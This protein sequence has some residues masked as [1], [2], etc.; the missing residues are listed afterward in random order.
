M[1]PLSPTDN[2]AA[3]W[4][5]YIKIPS[6]G[7]YTFRTVADNG[8][9]LLVNGNTLID[10][11]TNSSQRTLDSIS[12]NYTQGQLVTVTMD[13]YSSTGTSTAQLQWSY[14]GF[15]VTPVT[16]QLVP[17]SAFSQLSGTIGLRLNESDSSLTRS[18]KAGDTLQFSN[19]TS[20]R[21]ANDVTLSTTATVVNASLPATA[22]T[23]TVL[24]GETLSLPSLPAAQV[25]V[26][27]NDLPGFRI[28][29]D[30]AGLQTVLASDTITVNEADS[31]GA[32]VTRYLALTTQPTSTV[33]VYLE[34]SASNHGLL[35]APTSAQALAR[36][37]LTFTPSNW[38]IPQA[39]ATF[40]QQDNA[41]SGNANFAIFASSTS[42]DSLYNN[43]KPASNGKLFNVSKTDMDTPGIVSSAVTVVTG[44]GSNSNGSFTLKLNSKP[45][46]NVNVTLHPSDGQFTVNNASLNNDQTLVFTPDNWAIPQ[47]VQV[48]AVANTIV[49]DTTNSPL[50]IKSTSADPNYTNLTT[51]DV[52]IAITHNTLPTVRLELVGP[53]A[54]EDGQPATWRLVSNAPVPTSW[55]STGLVVGYNVT[56]SLS[57]ANVIGNGTESVPITSMV[58]G[59][60]SSGS[61]RI[62]PGQTTSNA[63]IM[64]ID[65]FAVDGVDKQFQLN[66][67]AGSGYTLDPFA[68]TATVS[69]K[70]NDVAGLMI[71]LAGERT[72]T[73]EGAGASQFQVCLLSQPSDTVTIQL[74]DISSVATGQSGTPLGQ[75]IVDN[76]TLTFTKDNWNVLQVVNV[77]ANDDNIIEDGTGLRAYTGIHT[78]QLQ[79][80][81][82]SNDGDYSSAGKP[83]AHFTKTSQAIDIVDR[84][85]DPRTYLGIDQALSAMMDGLNAMNLPIAGNLNGKTGPAINEFL[86][87]L[88]DS[89][90]TTPQL[91]SKKL[92][93]L[94]MDASGVNTTSPITMTMDSLGVSIDYTVSDAYNLYSIPLANDFGVPALGLQVSGSFDGSFDYSARLK[95]GVDKTRGFY[96]DTANSRLDAHYK[97]NLS[98]DFSLKG[99]LGFLQIDAVNQPSPHKSLGIIGEPIAGLTGERTGIDAT[100]RLKL[101]SPLAN[102]AES[103]YNDVTLLP[104]Q[105]LLSTDFSNL[106]RLHFTGQADGVLSVGMKAS[107]QDFSA[108]PLVSF[109]LST[110]M[111]LFYSTNPESPLPTLGTP[112]IP[113]PTNVFIDNLLLGMDNLIASLV[114]PLIT[115]IDGVLQPIYPFIQSLYDDTR[116][117]SRLGIGPKF[118]ANSDGSV[119]VIELAQYTANQQA[120]SNPNDPATQ[121]RLAAINRTVAFCDNLKAVI[122]LNEQLKSLSKDEN[123]LIE[124][125]NFVLSNFNLASTNSANSASAIN[126]D[127]VSSEYNQLASG[128]ATTLAA[129]TRIGAGEKLS[130][131]FNQLQ[132]LGFSVP[133][134]TEPKDIIKMLLG[135]PR[136]LITW[137]M[138][139]AGLSASM[140]QS[141]NTYGLHYGTASGSFDIQT[142]LNFGFDTVGLQ[143]WALSPF[144]PE[145]AHKVFDG[146]YVDAPSD[147]PQFDFDASI[148]V[149]QGIHISPMR[150]DFNGGVLGNAQMKLLDPGVISGTSDGKLRGAEIAAN[151]DDVTKLYLL[152]GVVT[153]SLNGQVQLGVDLGFYSYWKTVW[154]KQLN[155]LNLFS[156][157][158]TGTSASGS[159]SNSYL[160]GSTVFFDSNFNGTIDPGEPTAITSQDDGSYS[161]EID[162]RTFDTNQNGKI[163]PEEGMLVVYGGVDSVSK[164]PIRT[165]FV[166]PFG[167]MV[168]PLTSLYAYSLMMAKNF[169]GYSE[170]AVKAK[171]DK[172]F[173]L[174]NY[175]FLYQDPEKDLQQAEAAGQN[176]SFYLTPAQKT[177]AKNAYLAHIKLHLV[178]YYL[179][180]MG[181]TILPN[182][183][184]NDLPTK[185]KLNQEFYT[186]VIGYI[187]ATDALNPG[188]VGLTVKTIDRILVDVVNGFVTYISQATSDPLTIATV[189]SMLGNVASRA[190]EAFMQLD[191]IADNFEGK[192]FFD[193]VNQIKAAI[194]TGI[195]KEA[196][197]AVNFYKAPPALPAMANGAKVDPTNPLAFKASNIKAPDPTITKTTIEFNDTMMDF[198]ALLEGTKTRTSLGL[199]LKAFGAS[200]LSRLDPYLTGV[201]ESGKQLA[202]FAIDGDGNTTPFSYDPINDVGA[203]FYDLKR[204]GMADFIHLSYKDGGPGDMDGQVDGKISDPATTAVVDSTPSLR[205]LDA[206]TLQIGDSTI[207]VATA[208]FFSLTLQSNS[209]DL[210]EIGYVVLNA[211]DDP[212]AVSLADLLSN[213]QI[214]FSSLAKASS[215][216]I[217]STGLSRD[218]QITNNQKLLCFEVRGTSIQELAAGKTSV[219]ELGRQFQF[220]T[221]SAQEGSKT[222]SLNSTSGLSIQ[223]NLNN[224]APGLNALVSCDQSFAPVLN[225]S[226]L[227]GDQL[228]GVLSYNREASFNSTVGFYQVLDRNGSLF[229]AV[230][231]RTLDPTA[232]QAGDQARYRELALLAANRAAALDGIATTNGLLAQKEFSVVGGA[233]YAP[234]AIVASTQQTYFAFAAANTDGVNHFKMMGANVFGLEDMH[235]GGD[236]D[237]ND[238]LVG[239]DF[240]SY[241]P[242]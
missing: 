126:V 64:P 204:S 93:K 237:Y 69:I 20:L 112:K 230:T 28:S 215:L 178:S 42:N 123:F 12:Q 227:S 109:D 44:Q 139:I 37:P 203:R 206:R 32:G 217:G 54:G 219:A 94:L 128:A 162:N 1:S 167:S 75:L 26:I 186:R 174:G 46:A 39:F 161:L 56:N 14:S 72:M 134:I 19:G 150:A 235:G 122:D 154:K 125:G 36:I 100:F 177:S 95:M 105:K 117:F 185:L 68:S 13:Y 43:L 71:A 104:I 172:F 30:A 225:T 62:A 191:R 9:R 140:D 99:G 190:K 127:A 214:L 2:F 137:R 169:P 226:A 138:P 240:K 209:T 158:G 87:K 192:A 148:G 129:S 76:P 200:L 175:D 168:T 77:R 179:E 236:Q 97:T 193:N 166:A 187:E 124:Y 170:A 59:L 181:E 136:D 10:N 23:A 135:Q 231:G 228:T 132:A 146:F 223:L 222:A 183:F 213:G 41:V 180:T 98:P 153:S 73:I 34:S 216:S 15:G 85:L 50:Q 5:G 118:D 195:S 144:K 25:S 160:Q 40:P 48:Q 233:F 66:L 149:S 133:L 79:Y 78:G 83:V 29:S 17:A 173:L 114:K 49:Q 55:G 111:P 221:W 202:F 147:R 188:G 38:S 120:M 61:I 86:D 194:F 102:A 90:R 165:P 197:R 142:D 51:P 224:S 157:G 155:T 182:L 80:T 82:T 84:T 7:T 234:F 211:G 18:V 103:P 239:I 198:T 65:D 201:Q 131:I 110:K 74:S 151:S 116:V 141:F 115:A 210:S 101:A 21:I 241:V 33:T 156:F 107:L 27:D 205:L 3:R 57:S 229:D 4:T 92:E 199:S 113:N 212:N 184:P 145:D 16:N 218:L 96:F 108:I 208:L 242:I 60:L 232:L 152:T 163:D 22:S 8:I 35:K 58:Q 88:V 238:L 24:S 119:T 171:I 220:L 67:Q 130:S 207:N 70:D 45:T 47:Q 31:S 91:T 196:E 89:I 52:T 106:F 176:S 6:T 143:Q 164:A 11:W 159:A 53:R 81:F 189:K 63:F 121:E